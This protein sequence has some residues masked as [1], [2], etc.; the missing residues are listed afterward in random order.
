MDVS[1]L[2]TGLGE[3]PSQTS[4][5]GAQL[6]A[7]ICQHLEQNI[8]RSESA[9]P[10]INILRASSVI[11]RYSQGSALL[12]S[13]RGWSKESAH[14]SSNISQAVQQNTNAAGAE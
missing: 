4:D 13:T 12:P 11:W 14:K 7:S 9:E 8:L 3:W 6:V 1:I 5:A 2:T 10:N